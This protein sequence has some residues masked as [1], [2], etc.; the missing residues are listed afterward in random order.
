M[1]KP[2]PHRNTRI[3]LIEK[4]HK[5]LNNK[6]NAVCDSLNQVMLNQN[7]INAVFAQAAEAKKAQE[8]KHKL[9]KEKTDE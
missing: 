8:D 2:K 9:E 6:V 5:E 4:D 7:K 1:S 3:D